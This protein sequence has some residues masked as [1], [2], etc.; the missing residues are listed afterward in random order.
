[1]KSIASNYNIFICCCPSSPP[2]RLVR[3]PQWTIAAHLIRPVS[4]FSFSHDRV[5]RSLVAST[6]QPVQF[7][8]TGQNRPICS[9][10]SANAFFVVCYHPPNA[11]RF[12]WRRLICRRRR[13]REKLIYKFSPLKKR[14]SDRLHID[15]LLTVIVSSESPPPCTWAY[16]PSPLPPAQHRVDWHSPA[17]HIITAIVVDSVDFSVSSADPQKFPLTHSRSRRNSTHDVIVTAPLAAVIAANCIL[18]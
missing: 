6:D 2:V 17:K 18:C 16:Y 4:H 8:W 5:M 13:R 12:R 14:S 3:A 15:Q 10:T 7:G 11:E 1:M 9:G